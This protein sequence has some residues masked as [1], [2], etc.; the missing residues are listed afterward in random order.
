MRPFLQMI[1]AGV[2]ALSACSP[3][4]EIESELPPRPTKTMIV[5]GVEPFETLRLPAIIEASELS[6]LTFQVPGQINELPVSAGDEVQ[7]GQVLARLDDRDYRNQL[8]SAQAAFDRADQEYERA[9]ALID[10]NAIARATVDQRLA[11]RNIAKASLDTAQK[12][13]S[14]TVLKAPFAGTVAE[15]RSET[16]E[17]IAASTPII[18]LQAERVS[19]AVVQ[20][21]ASV[22]IDAEQIEDLNTWIELD[23][24]PGIEIPVLMSETVARADAA[25]QTFEVSFAFEAPEDLLILPGMTGTLTGQFTRSNREQSALSLPISAIMS[26]AGRTFVWRVDQETQSVSRRDVETGAALGNELRVLSG[27]QAGDQI[28]IAGGPYLFEGAEIRPFQANGA[29]Q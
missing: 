8:A 21:P 29:D 7:Q 14:D 3:S 27:L 23:A 6:V 24:A 25:T 18:T 10:S 17:T 11:D 16:F 12:R 26:D 20:M 5:E 22:V 19:E 9:R 1:T 2:I 28:V 15:V 13:V 4:P